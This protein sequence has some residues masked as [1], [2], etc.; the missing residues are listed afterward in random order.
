MGGRGVPRKGPTES[1]PIPP[2]SHSPV[3]DGR[4]RDVATTGQGTPTPESTCL[5]SPVWTD[6]NEVRASGIKTSL[7]P[8]GASGSTQSPSQRSGPRASSMHG[9]QGGVTRSPRLWGVWVSTPL[10]PPHTH[11]RT[12]R[13]AP[14]LSTLRGRRG[15]CRGRPETSN[16]TSGTSPPSSK[17]TLEPS[18]PPGPQT[19]TPPVPGAGQALRGEGTVSQTKSVEGLLLG[20]YFAVCQT[21]IGLV[22]SPG[23]PGVPKGI[24]RDPRASPRSSGTRT[25]APRTERRATFDQDPRGHWRLGDGNGVVREGACQSRAG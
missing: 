4:R 3:L 2:G 17:E 10:L 11:G 7:L 8:W 25:R 9:G 21:L 16:E 22:V 24:T 13:D 1:S 23:S 19:P 20:Y 18:G 6:R 14:S 5:P 15:P 12:R